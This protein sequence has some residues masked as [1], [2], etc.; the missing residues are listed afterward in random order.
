MSLERQNQPQQA[1]LVLRED[2][3]VHPDHLDSRKLLVRL[4]ALT[5]DL[6]AARTEAEQIARRTP[7]GDPT[8]LIEVGHA[9]E[10][11]HHFDLALAAYDDAAARA[12]LSPAGPR[13]GGLRAARWGEVEVAL[14]RLTEAVRRGAEDTETLHALGLVRLHAGD[15]DGA[16][17]AYVRCSVHDKEDTSCLLG[18]A[19]LAL[20]REDH[21]AGLAAY[22]GVLARRRDHVGALLGRAYCLLMLGEKD[23]GIKAVDRAE[24]LGAPAENVKRLRGLALR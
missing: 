6:G 4:L 18:L 14:P 13:E 21:K 9:E 3:R 15:R 19:T 10:L 24:S 17:E 22:D 7:D 5:G 11:A 8:A 23:A 16:A 1:I 12:P 20:M 2:L